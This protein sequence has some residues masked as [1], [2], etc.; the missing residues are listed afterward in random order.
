MVLD[1]RAVEPLKARVAEAMREFFDAYDGPAAVTAQPV[2]DQ[3]QI[4]LATAAPLF[5]MTLADFETQP[6]ERGAVARALQGLLEL[7]PGEAATLMALV[8]EGDTRAVSFPDVVR[9]LERGLGHAQ[10]RDVVSAL[11][12]VAYSDAE[13]IAHEEY[14]IRKVADL[15]H[16]ST[17]D[18]VEAK[19]RAREEFR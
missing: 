10:K 5:Q 4:R 13:I 6:A 16:L 9:I 14:F 7:S 18:L 15:L 12:K 8:S 2:P 1:E 11:W 3:R 19:V 17:A